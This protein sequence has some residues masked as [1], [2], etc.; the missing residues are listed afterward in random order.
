MKIT[1]L[2]WELL[3]ILFKDGN[4]ITKLY[5]VEEGFCFPIEHVE[6]CMESLKDNTLYVSI[7]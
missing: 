1:K 6:V 5:V 2:V 7:E 3:K 4:L